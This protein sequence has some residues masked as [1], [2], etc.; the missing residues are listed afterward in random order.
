MQGPFCL[1]N[2]VHN[3]LRV[4]V[5]HSQNLGP[6]KVSF[7]SS[8]REQMLTCVCIT[9]SMDV[10]LQSTYFWFSISC[11]TL[12]HHSKNT[13][14]LY[15]CTISILFGSGSHQRHSGYLMPLS[16]LH[17]ALP[18]RRTSSLSRGRHD[19]SDSGRV[20]STVYIAT[21]RTPTQPRL[22][23]DSE[24]PQSRLSADSSQT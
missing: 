15:S 2:S 20:N 3:V 11:F 8:T 14:Y 24:S 1:K 4:P 22:S 19:T 13:Q 10:L 18:E 9:L 5:A 6:W 16:S 23:S 21:P 17:R 12:H 7:F